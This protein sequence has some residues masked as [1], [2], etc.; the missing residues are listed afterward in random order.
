M[1]WVAFENET[2]FTNS[3]ELLCVDA[4]VPGLKTELQAYCCDLVCL[5]RRLRLLGS[6]HRDQMARLL[7][8]SRPEF[9]RPPPPLPSVAPST[10][11]RGVVRPGPRPARTVKRVRT[12]EPQKDVSSEPRAAGILVTPPAR[13]LGSL[14]QDSCCSSSAHTRS[15]RPTSGALWRCVADVARSR[16][17][18]ALRDLR[19]EL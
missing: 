15:R 8:A 14:L 1:S 10:T 3:L 12:T 2:D 19:A 18:G 17:A 11:V 9:T 16:Q 5:W 4:G 6:S 13:S 7:A